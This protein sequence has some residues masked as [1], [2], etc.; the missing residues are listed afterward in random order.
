MI[1]WI[2]ENFEEVGSTNDLARARGEGSVVVAQRQTAGRGQGE[3]T[4]ESEEGKNLTFSVVF[5]PRFLAV[6]DAFELSLMVAGAVKDAL[7]EFGI[8]AWVKHPNDV[9]VVEQ[10]IAGILIENDVR[11]DL[12]CR[13][14]AGVGLNVNQVEFPADLPNPVSMHLLT[15][16]EY[17]LNVVLKKVLE[18]IAERYER[19]ATKV[20]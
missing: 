18:A 3:H 9:W 16:K 6:G 11:G 14:V 8:E 4:W 15:G 10:K 7:A 2:V 19:L 17:D 1:H 12:L 20:K 5:E 13:T